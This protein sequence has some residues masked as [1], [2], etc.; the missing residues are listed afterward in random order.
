VYAAAERARGPDPGP[1]DTRPGSGSFAADPPFG[2][3]DAL[4]GEPG[5]YAPDCELALSCEGLGSDGSAA[6][7]AETLARLNAA[8]SDVGL[9]ALELRVVLPSLSGFELPSDAVCWRPLDPDAEL[10]AGLLLPENYDPEMMQKRARFSNI[11]LGLP[12]GG[13][14]RLRA[15]A[16][17]C[18]G[19]TFDRLH[20]GH[21]YE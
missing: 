2:G 10:N 6:F 7:P 9:C 8:R 5:R 11:N 20:A 21:K 19:G 13:S 4:F 12:G 17:V 3:P 1:G 16:N 15:Y 18:A 14:A